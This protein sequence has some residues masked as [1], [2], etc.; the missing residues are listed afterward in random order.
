MLSWILPYLTGMF[1]MSVII[2]TVREKDDN[3]WREAAF[4]ALWPLVMFVT[5]G[6]ALGEHLR[7][8]EEVEET[9]DA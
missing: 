5:L 8:R 9:D 4:A 6:T 7:A 2:G 1:V 3:V